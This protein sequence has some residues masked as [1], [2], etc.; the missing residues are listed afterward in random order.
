MS[1]QL[2]YQR[3]DI[4]SRTGRLL[5]SKRT[6]VEAERL[7]GAWFNALCVIGV[8]PDGRG[9]IVSERKELHA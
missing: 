1:Q 5:D 9:E 3:F 8:K 4:Y 7:L 2:T 6:Q